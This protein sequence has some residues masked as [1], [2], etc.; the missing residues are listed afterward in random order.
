M[1]IIIAVIGAVVGA[2]VTVMLQRVSIPKIKFGPIICLILRR[3]KDHYRKDGSIV[4]HDCARCGRSPLND[5]M[6]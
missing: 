2:V 3:H 4:Y 1:E 6:D 5:L